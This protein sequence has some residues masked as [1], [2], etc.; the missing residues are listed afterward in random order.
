[1]NFRLQFIIIGESKH[2]IVNKVGFAELR[3]VKQAQPAPPL[4]ES[5]NF[6]PTCTH[7]FRLQFDD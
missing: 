3:L 1:M 5:A 4:T 6:D 7:C 2:S